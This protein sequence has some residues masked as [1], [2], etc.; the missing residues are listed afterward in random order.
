MHRALRTRQHT[1]TALQYYCTCIMYCIDNIISYSTSTVIC[2]CMC[3]RCKLRGQRGSPAPVKHGHV[4]PLGAPNQDARP[5]IRCHD[6]G[7]QNFWGS[8]P[9]PF[10]LP[11]L[12]V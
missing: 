4:R 12:G 1:N 8:M 2:T 11:G 7:V 3:G 10:S 5:C 9:C 6:G